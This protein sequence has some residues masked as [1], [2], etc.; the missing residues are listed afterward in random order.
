MSDSSTD[1]RHAV[2][3]LRYGVIVGLARKAHQ[4]YA[5]P[6][7]ARTR[8]APEPPRHWLKRYRAGEFA[9]RTGRTTGRSVCRRSIG[10]VDSGAF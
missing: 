10:A 7:S 8:I 9:E 3:L 2:A 5:I 4:E 6:G 1:V